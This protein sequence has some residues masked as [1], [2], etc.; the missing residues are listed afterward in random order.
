MES[1]ARRICVTQFNSC[2][3][4]DSFEDFKETSQCPWTPGSSS[5]NWKDSLN[6]FSQVPVILQR[7]MKQRALESWV[8]F[9]TAHTRVLLRTWEGLSLW[10]LRIILPCLKGKFMDM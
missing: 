4:A 6:S 8:S 5:E 7:P 2:F 9:Q 10:S 1:K 3:I